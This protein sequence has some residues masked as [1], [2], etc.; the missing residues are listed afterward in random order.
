[1]IGSV[2]EATRLGRANEMDVTIAFSGLG[3]R[4][5]FLRLGRREEDG[6]KDAMAATVDKGSPLAR[7]A[8]ESRAPQV[9]R[10]VF[11]YPGFL[12]HLLGAIRGGL[13]RAGAAPGWPRDIHFQVLSRN[14]FS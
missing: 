2:L 3:S 11:D 10:L 13:A 7:F 9:K 6:S 8:R 12:R 4:R 14:K 5:D 1:M